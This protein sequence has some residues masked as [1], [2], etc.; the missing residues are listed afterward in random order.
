[1]KGAISLLGLSSNTL[2]GGEG[3]NGPSVQ[4]LSIDECVE[5]PVDDCLAIG[6]S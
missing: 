1:M 2:E 4:L 5:L 3:V 6:I